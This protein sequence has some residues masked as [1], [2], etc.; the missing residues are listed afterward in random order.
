MWLDD[1]GSLLDQVGA[2]VTAVI[3]VGIAVVHIVILVVG[4]RWIRDAIR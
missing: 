3:L 2:A 1:V 4:H